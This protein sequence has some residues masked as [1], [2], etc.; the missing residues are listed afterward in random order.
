M[1][2]ANS[3]NQAGNAFESEIRAFEKLD[4][5]NPPVKAAI[6]FVGSS[7]IRL[8]KDLD[9]AFPDHR[10]LNRGF[11]GSET[12]DVIYFFDRV[13]SVYK[14]SKII[15]YE[16]DN[17]IANG[18]T[19]SEVLA[20]FKIFIGLVNKQL[21]GSPVGFIAIKPSPSRWDKHEEMEIANNR[22]SKLAAKTPN[23]QF[24]DVYTRMLGPDG[25]PIP[26]I[27]LSDSLHMNERG[28]DIWIDAV[29]PFVN[30]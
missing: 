3:V 17:D 27:F 1:I 26:E 25:K 20:D 19:A 28:Y 15:F 16:G 6:L 7:S 24:I 22:I 11:G 23:L 9:T 21:P 14:P 8:W 5:L 18:K 29:S 30:K 13:V 2:L 10:V 4:L 12:S